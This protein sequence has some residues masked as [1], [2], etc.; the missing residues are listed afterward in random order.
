ML[1]LV[2]TL[3][4]LA[5][6]VM[7]TIPM[8]QNAVVRQKEQ[9][10][11]ESLREIR[12]AVDEFKRDTYG[13]CTQGAGAVNTGNPTNP[14]NPGAPPDPRSR[15]YI[16]DCKIFDTDNVDHYPP[17]LETLVKGVRVKSRSPNLTSGNG[18]NDNSPQAT[19]LNQEKEIKKVYLREIP[20]DPM[21]GEKDWKF[22]SSYQP[23][24]SDSWDEINVFDVRTASEGEAMNGEKYSDW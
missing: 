10:L 16:D 21:T 20:V 6:L 19:E 7:G 13:A 11:R 9:K 23:V 5:V 2:C 24:D 4:V 14:I 15:V 18:I 1:E 3:G 12:S 8:A 22:R 17:D